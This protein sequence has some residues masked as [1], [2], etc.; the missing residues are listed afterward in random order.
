MPP[1]FVLVPGSGLSCSLV[2]SL[3]VCLSALLGPAGGAGVKGLT[4]GGVYKKETF[5]K[6]ALADH[7]G[8][9]YIDIWGTVYTVPA[10][11][12]KRICEKR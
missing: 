11:G 2:S 7:L 4:R 12:K 1:P 8:N 10:R 3:L 9:E 6:G 5:Y